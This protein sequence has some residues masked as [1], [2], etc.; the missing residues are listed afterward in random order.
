VRASFEPDRTTEKAS[1]NMETVV[2]DGRVGRGFDSS[3]P[4]DAV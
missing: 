4:S 3:R 1:I 2:T